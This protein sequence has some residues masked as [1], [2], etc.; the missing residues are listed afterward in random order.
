MRPDAPIKNYTIKHNMLIVNK[1]HNQTCIIAM[2]CT[3]CSTLITV[4]STLDDQRKSCNF[5]EFFFLEKNVRWQEKS[6]RRAASPITYEGKLCSQLCSLK[7]FC[8]II[9]ML[10]NV[11]KLQSVNVFSY[12]LATKF[13]L[14][15]VGVH[16]K[17]NHIA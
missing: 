11:N 16:R 12:F 17:S 7:V 6:A 9:L 14:T 8:S 1:R 5:L 10:K 3:V 15:Q 13:L 2:L 4:K